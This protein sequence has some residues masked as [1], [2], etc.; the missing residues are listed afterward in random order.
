MVQDGVDISTY[1]PK[2]FNEST[3]ILSSPTSSCDNNDED[4]KKVV[5]KLI[6]LCSCGDAMKNHLV[7]RSKS[8][9]EWNVDAPSEQLRL[10][11][12]DSFRRVSLE[13]KTK[14]YGLMTDLLSSAT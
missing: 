6:I 13:I 4:G 2:T 3:A 14:V 8:V 12:E 5:D 1:F 7:Q 9:E 11:E 10:G